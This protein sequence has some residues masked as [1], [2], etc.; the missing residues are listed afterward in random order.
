MATSR[1]GVEESGILLQPDSAETPELY[2]LTSSGAHPHLNPNFSKFSITNNFL[3]IDP[4]NI[5][6]IFL[7]SY[8]SIN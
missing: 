8:N 6:L 2:R 5:I 1:A 4:I 3:D 7:N